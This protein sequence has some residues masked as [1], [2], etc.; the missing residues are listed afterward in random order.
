MN[1]LKA[2][3]LI[4]AIVALA[5][6]SPPVDAQRIGN[7]AK[8]NGDALWGGNAINWSSQGTPTTKCTLTTSRA[9]TQLAPWIDVMGADVINLAADL[10]SI[11]DPKNIKLSYQLSA[12][13][14]TWKTA[15]V[16]D[17]LATAAVDED[18]FIGTT[19]ASSSG[20]TI[21]TF[22][23]SRY[24]RLILAQYTVNTTDSVAVTIRPYVLFKSR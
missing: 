20:Y 10:T 3:W 22:Q 17:T 14:K 18:I 9:D 2:F 11:S 24:M 23:D 12:N 4:V 21:T 5:V 15:A 1:R 16:M 7:D 8:G 6:A 19:Q 13:G